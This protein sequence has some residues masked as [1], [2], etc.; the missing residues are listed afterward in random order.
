MVRLGL[1][2]LSLTT[3]AFLGARQALA[4]PIQSASTA[5]TLTGNVEADFP[6]T[7]DNVR[8][9]PV[10]T[11]PIERRRQSAAVTRKPALLR[12]H[13][14]IR[15]VSGSHRYLLCPNARRIITALSAARHADIDQLT[16]M[17]A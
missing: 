14:L 5:V 15:K 1:V 17:A 16:R 2:R 10:S 3:L 4:G 12:A 6:Q 11:N 13:G 9:I 8:V 7:S